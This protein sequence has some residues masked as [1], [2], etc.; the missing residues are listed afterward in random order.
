MEMESRDNLEHLKVGYGVVDI[1]REPFRLRERIPAEI[2]DYAQTSTLSFTAAGKQLRAGDC[3]LG[4][5]FWAELWGSLRRPHWSSG[6]SSSLDRASEC[7]VAGPNVERCVALHE[8]FGFEKIA[9]FREVGKKFD[10]WIDVRYW[11]LP[12]VV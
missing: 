5:R 12:S 2:P 8:K 9:H 11:Q 3:S 10:H 6:R 4:S 7:G 1:D